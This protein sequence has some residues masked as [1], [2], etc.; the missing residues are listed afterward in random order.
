[1][2]IPNKPA[3]IEPPTIQK[4]EKEKQKRECNKKAY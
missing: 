2:W 1:L 3:D 4:A